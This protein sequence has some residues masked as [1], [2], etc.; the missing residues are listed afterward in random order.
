MTLKGCSED[1]RRQYVSDGF[2][3]IRKFL[4]GESLE[5]MLSNVSRLLREVLPAIPSEQVFYEDSTNVRSL[6]QIQHLEEHDA[7]FHQQF[8]SG[9]FC[10]LAETLLGEAVITKN[11]QYFNKTAGIG[12]ATPA[13]Q[14]GHYFMLTPCKALTM[15]LALDDADEDNGCVRYVR[16]SHRKGMREHS[17]TNTLGFSQG[18]TDF[19]KRNDIEC[20]I[21]ATAQPGDLLVH[22]ALTIHRA[23]ANS[24][25]SR[26]RR[27]I[28]LIFYAASAKEDTERHQAY[29]RSLT[30]DWKRAGKLQ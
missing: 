29:Q 6:K 21:A 28:G 20:E 23:D 16:A 5:T 18:I 27:A 1:D 2:L 15:W 3:A 11:V 7:W 24:S 19:P 8:T 4:S 14:D 22:D 26:D 30:D 10:Q 12:E 17:R 13:H 9:P 25:R